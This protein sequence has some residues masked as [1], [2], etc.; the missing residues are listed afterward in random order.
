MMNNKEFSDFLHKSQNTFRD[1]SITLSIK[2]KK[3]EEIL[4]IL[5]NRFIPEPTFYFIETKLLT[6]IFELKKY[7]KTEKYPLKVV[8]LLISSGSKASMAKLLDDGILNML[9]SYIPHRKPKILAE[10][11]YILAKFAVVSSQVRE[12]IIKSGYF[13][14]LIDLLHKENEPNIIQ[15]LSYFIYKS[16]FDLSLSLIPAFTS[17]ITYLK[18]LLACSNIKAVILGNVYESLYNLGSIYEGGL[19]N[20]LDMPFLRSFEE[21]KG[22]SNGEQ[23]LLMSFVKTL[24]VFI[25]VYNEEFIIILV[26]MRFIDRLIS[27]L[28]QDNTPLQRYLLEIFRNIFQK[29][30]KEEILEIFIK[31][32]GLIKWIENTLQKDRKERFDFCFF[33]VCTWVFKNPVKF[34]KEI[35][36]E[37]DCFN[38]LLYVYETASS[39]E[40]RIEIL[41]LFLLYLKG[42]TAGEDHRDI[43]KGLSRICL[44]DR[45][46]EEESQALLRLKKKVKEISKTGEV[47]LEKDM[48]NLKI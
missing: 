12:T 2:I 23:G 8:F 7:E 10:V 43:L 16:S 6:D 26:Q 20:G 15:P 38:T 11:A 29:N 32:K 42:F 34:G 45:E 46:D 25:K 39:K 13:S 5:S 30:N 22:F 40:K 36:K 47:V 24:G 21:I 19:I 4:Q 1:K 3:F 41:G 14:L 28:I 48:R 9:F 44:I 31:A 35:N 33:M 27:L 37:S 18:S 17:C